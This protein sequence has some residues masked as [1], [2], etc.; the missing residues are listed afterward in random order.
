[1]TANM[2]VKILVV[3]D[4][5]D[6][7][8]LVRQRFRKQVRD[9]VYAFAFAQ[10]GA[11]AIKQIENDPETELVLTDINM[12]VMDGL[13]LLIKLLELNPIIQPV[14]V[15]AY[16]DMKNIRTAMNRGAFDFLTK[17]IDFEDFE[18]TINNA[19]NQLRRL[20]EADQNRDQ[21]ASVQREL[22]V[23]RSIQQSMLPHGFLP[24]AG[25][26]ALDVAATMLPARN[27]GGDFYDYF[28]L[29]ADRFGFVIGDVSGKGVP[30]ALFMA[31]SRTV[32]KAVALRGQPPGECLREVNAFLC[33]ENHAE[34]FVTVF[35]GI[36]NFRTGQLQHSNGG[37]NPP[38]VLTAGGE[39]TALDAE[40]SGTVLGMLEDADYP[41]C[42]TQLL[43]GDALFLYT[44][45]VTEATDPQGKMFG[46]ERL[47][48]FLQQ[49]K[50][51]SA[52]D[53]V[54]GDLTAVQQF[55]AGAAQSDDITAVAVRYLGTAMTP[56]VD[57]QAES[58][59]WFRHLT[60]GYLFA[61][62]LIALLA[63]I[64]Q[65]LI[66][67]TISERASDSHVV[68]LAGRQRMLSQRLVNLVLLLGRATDG[69]E[70]LRLLNDLRQDLEVWDTTHRGLQRGDSTLGLPG[71]NSASI[72]ELFAELEPH[73]AGIH[74]AV[75]EVLAAYEKPGSDPQFQAKLERHIQSMLTRE[76]SFVAG[77]NE[78]VQQFA[79]EADARGKT[80]RSIAAIVFVITLVVLVLTGL[81]I[82]RPLAQRF[83]GLLLTNERA[84]AEL[85][86]NSQDLSATNL[87]LMHARDEALQIN[88]RL[89]QKSALVEILQRV[90]VAANQAESLETALQIGID[91]VC[92]YTGWPVGHAYIVAEDGS[93]ELEPYGVWHLDDPT[94]FATFR[95]ITEETRFR[96]GV[97]LPGE[98]LSTGKPLWIMDVTRHANFPRAKA[99]TDIGVK[100]AFG[101]PL[102]VG[103]EVYG[104]LE[105][106]ASVPK[107]PDEALLQTMAHIGT[108]L[109]RVFE[110]LRRV[111]QELR[112]AKLATE[113]RNDELEQALRQLKTAQEQLIVQEK[114]A[115]LGALTAGI[116]HEIKNPL[117]FVINFGQLAGDLL[118][119][120][121]DELAKQK[122]LFPRAVS[123]NVNDLLTNLEQNLGKIREHGKRANN[124]VSGM[125]MHS[126]GR[127]G[128]RQS[129]DLNALL[130]QYVNLA[131][132]GQRSQ[133]ASFNV[134]LATHYDQSLT[135]VSIVPQDL[136]RVFLNLAANAFYAVAEKK[137]KSPGA[138]E[139]TV[140]V[141]TK[142]QG[143]RV[144]IRI[145][146]NADGIPKNIRDKLFQ[147][148]VTTKAL[149][150]GTGLGL[151]ISYDIVVHG[152]Q[153]AI[154]VETEE[155][156][157]TEFIVTIPASD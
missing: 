124:I 42:Q 154:G 132:H 70:R 97:G 48:V 36:L 126:R 134:T 26:A 35:Y 101:F 120:L 145:R 130:A 16:S 39:L 19:L 104:V 139:P 33:G 20:K 92:A 15:S 135:P 121:A 41:T 105:F 27:V 119:E 131:Y 110:R 38:Y 118:S 4:E 2:T 68:D 106:F 138:Y 74:V 71:N 149:G 147:P 144:E 66:Q 72:Q 153:G 151:S 18:I 109:G 6:L 150:A 65:I 116:A 102:L 140:S 13:T 111:E 156:S 76:N 57:S 114:L 45:G 24:F 25:S 78:I 1:M 47:E 79:A 108:Q 96:P 94:R 107:E 136:G 143:G 59:A 99:A 23:A 91:E 40:M 69:P 29:D 56:D 88:A 129:T 122:D 117:N 46:V 37:H 152:H 103:T 50:A 81:L 62:G 3:D 30:A 12:P 82:F 112:R 53:L 61:L 98:V 155:G 128:E 90:A 7:E 125:L 32:L 80:I 64:G 63:I 127:T 84:R 11:E 44:D 137:R 95:K 21:L 115:S 83:H 86:L 28:Q 54:Q 60:M 8:S 5:P 93:R 148:F 85:E 142:K 146:D 87:K 17:P 75:S 113:Q 141:A 100:G 73:K 52:D 58:K 43:A 157:G 55:A 77:M 67:H 10:N 49:S 51:P 133:D 123:E 34:L 14:V 31:M 22:T 89:G 9:K